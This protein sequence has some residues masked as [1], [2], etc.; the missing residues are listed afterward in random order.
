MTA[1]PK[2]Q[3]SDH[4]V[5]LPYQK[6]WIE[7]ESTWKLGEKTRRSGFT[8]A[9]GADAVLTGAAAKDE[10]GRDHF[11]VGSNKEMAREFIDACAMWAK[12]F[13]KASGDIQEE[14]LRDED[15]DILVFTIYFPSGN[16]IQALSSRPSNMRGMQG[17]VTLDEA[18]HQ[19]QLAEL[20]KAAA[21]LTMWGAKVRIISTH[22]GADNLFNE[23]IQ[24]SR[25][26]KKRYSIHRVTLD[27][28]CE[29]GLYRRI[30]Q[31][32]KQV[33]SP[34]AEKQWKAD[35]LADTASREDALE[36]YY[37]AP[38]SGGGGYLSRAL[39]ESRMD[40]A[41]PVLRF[42]GSAEFNALPVSKRA[43]D[44]EAWIE[45]NL[46]PLLDALDPTDQYALG[47]DFARTGDLTVLAP[48][49]IKINLRKVVPF[50]VELRNVPFAQQ[51]QVLFY[52]LRRLPN[53]RGA[54]L[55]AR[56]NGQNIAEDAID[57]FGA[58]VEAV[59][60]TQGWYLENMP[61]LKA[62][63]EDDELTL[64]KD[65]GVLDDL[66]A[67]QI[68]KGIPKVPDSDTN[69]QQ[70]GLRRHGDAAVAICMAV[71]AAQRDV[72]I[73]EYESVTV[74]SSSSDD[75]LE[76]DIATTHGF[77]GMRGGAL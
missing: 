21:A 52:L 29:Q 30:C 24:D 19:D 22:N 76:R 62:G 68:V 53:K 73:F 55:D 39:I 77:G 75:R 57:E 41:L 5:L 71:Y 72:E 34:E 17:N 50:I 40:A 25:A 33:W 10:G 20:L 6:T 70:G 36:E 74:R 44:M 67:V 26:G 35:L 45:D 64:P 14:I 16:K 69:T 37:C 43:V 32:T 18:A 54:A 3:Y 42:E 1:K 63:L 9:E 28:A 60:I 13:N 65:R 56:G 58:L 59:M 2:Y 51:K 8:W 48:L 31:V 12:A 49:A 15:K 38:K 61:K 66:R 11:Y 4:E 47:E 7:D 23:L 46:K 27:D